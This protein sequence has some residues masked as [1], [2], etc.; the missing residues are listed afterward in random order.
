M[1]A[2]MKALPLDR[3]AI[4]QKAFDTPDLRQQGCRAFRVF[5]DGAKNMAPAVRETLYRWVDHPELV[6]R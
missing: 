6:D 4:L 1:L 3:H 5:A 2:L